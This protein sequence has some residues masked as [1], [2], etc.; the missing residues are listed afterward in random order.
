MLGYWGLGL[1]WGCYY[2]FLVVLVWWENPLIEARVWVLFRSLP[3]GL[4]EKLPWLFTLI[5]SYL[6]FYE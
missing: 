2:G 1:V 6:T 3:C 4:L 5:L